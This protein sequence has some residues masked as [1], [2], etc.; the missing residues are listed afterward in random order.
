M[1]FE[2]NEYGRSIAAP[3]LVL[4]DQPYTTGSRV[5]A[6]D[7]LSEGGFA[8]YGKKGE[9][10]KG[11]AASPES[12]GYFLGIAQRVVTRDEYPIG[13][14]VTV[15]TAGQIW[16]KVEADVSSGNGAFITTAGGWGAAGTA[17]ANATYRTS[18]KSG[19]YAVIELK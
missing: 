14:P 12:D 8:V 5:M 13:T 15:V 6:E 17:V 19:G 10:V 18:A 11:Y 3:G 2:A 1:A 9:D 16:V 4:N 7:A